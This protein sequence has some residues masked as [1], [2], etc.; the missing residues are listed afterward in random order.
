MKR[1][2]LLSAIEKVKPALSDGKISELSGMLIFDNDK[3]IGAGEEITICVPLDTDLKAVIPADEFTR[4]LNKFSQEDMEIDADEKELHVKAGKTEV[5]LKMVEAKDIPS[6]DFEEEDWR[7]LP[8]DFDE[9]LG[10]CTFSASDQASMGV[11]TCLSVD[12]KRILSSDNFRITERILSEEIDLE[13]PILIPS[14]IA[15]FLSTF[16]LKEILIT[17]SQAVYRNHD[18]AIFAHTLIDDNFEDVDEYLNVEGK[19]IDFPV[20]L[21][22][23]LSRVQVLAEES[24]KLKRVTIT[25]DNWEIIAKCENIK[26]KAI[27]PVPIKYKGKKI[28]FVASPEHLSSIIPKANKATV[29]DGALLFEGDNFRHAVCLIADEEEAPTTEEPVETEVKPEPKKRGRG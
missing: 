17:D 14:K 2:E 9:A 3:L 22:A 24:N 8:E 11:L 19:K 15:H 20:E 5:W 27:E 29:S 21:C 4:L 6:F 23:A 25:V 12:G 13:K 26:G 10:F 1:K 18:G 28:E 16:G 7:P